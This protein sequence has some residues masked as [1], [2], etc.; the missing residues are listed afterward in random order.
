MIA[1]VRVLPAEEFEPTMVKLASEYEDM[2]VGQI[3]STF[4]KYSKNKKNNRVQKCQQKAHH[5]SATDAEAW[6]QKSGLSQKV[7]CL[8]VT[9]IEHMIKY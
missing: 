7:A 5:L 4:K 3:R 9:S 8:L 6:K 1:T 2:T